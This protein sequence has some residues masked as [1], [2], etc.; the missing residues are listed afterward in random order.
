[1][2]YMVDVVVSGTVALD[3]I[4]TPFGEVKEVLGGSAVYSSV[5]AREFARA[6]I[7]SVVGKDFPKK[8]LNFLVTMGIDTAGID[9]KKGDTFRWKGYYEYDMNQAHT[10]DTKLNVLTTF[11]PILPD[12]Y[13]QAK[14]L[15]LANTDPEVQMKVYRQMKKPR[16][17]M[18]DTMNFWIDN[19][20]DALT[21]MIERVDVVV[22]NDA[23]ARQYWD[24]PNLVQAG[25]SFLEMGLKAVI[26]K[27]GEHGALMFTD[28]ACFSAPAYPL[29]K[30]VDPTG[31]GDS[32]AGGFIDWLARTEDLSPRNMRKAVIFGSAIASFNAEDFSLNKLKK[33]TRDDIFNRYMMFQDIVSF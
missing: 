30:L 23:E 19:T 1:M 4:R 6:G 26:I 9:V 12:A 15:F 31:A 21:K 24:T 7:V 17:V 3:S 28:G 2:F 18:M 14:F 11:D 25:R 22:L 27:K 13:R 5:A 8:Y 20:K 33:I 16:F 29:E 10:L 32:F